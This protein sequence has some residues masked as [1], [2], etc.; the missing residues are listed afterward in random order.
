[1]TEVCGLKL[2][3]Y[4]LKAETNPR[5]TL[6]RPVTVRNRSSANEQAITSRTAGT[7]AIGWLEYQTSELW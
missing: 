1:M 5:F 6:Q 3:A 4:W 7:T 2:H